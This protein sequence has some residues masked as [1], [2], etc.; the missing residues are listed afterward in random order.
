MG[1]QHHEGGRMG[2]AASVLGFLGEGRM[3]KSQDR[4]ECTPASCLKVSDPIH[5]SDVNQL[6]Q[7]EMC[8]LCCS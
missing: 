4:A 3:C 7:Y 6:K 5:P 1:A 2:S 8:C